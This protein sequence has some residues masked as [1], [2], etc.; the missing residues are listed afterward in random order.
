MPVH[1]QAFDSARPPD[2]AGGRTEVT[3]SRMR[4][5]KL[6]PPGPL[7][8]IPRKTSRHIIFAA[9]PIEKTVRMRQTLQ[10]LPKS[11]S[12]PSLTM[13]SGSSPSRP[14]SLLPRLCA[15]R[16]RD[17]EEPE[18]GDDAQPGAEGDAWMSLHCG[19]RHL[20]IPFDGRLSD[21]AREA[22]P[23]VHWYRKAE[24]EAEHR[25]SADRLSDS[26]FVKPTSIPWATERDITHAAMLRAEPGT[27]KALRFEGR[28]ELYAHLH[29]RATARG[30]EALAEAFAFKLGG[31]EEAHRILNLNGTGEISLMEFVGC[32]SLLGFDLH[33]L[34]GA[35]ERTAFSRIDI[36]N[37]GTIRVQDI[38][39]RHRGKRRGLL[40]TVASMAGK[41]PP[42][43]GPEPELPSAMAVS[44]TSLASTSDW[45][46]P[47]VGSMAGS[48]EDSVE[49]RLAKVKWIAIAKWMAA[50]QQRSTAIRDQRVRHG[51]E[52]NA[53]KSAVTEEAEEAA[54]PRLVSSRTALC[55]SS[56]AEESIVGNHPL[57]AQSAVSS[58]VPRKGPRPKTCS[59]VTKESAVAMREQEY[60]IR[61]SFSKS[62]S[63]SLPDGSKLLSKS[64]LWNFFQDLERVEQHPRHRGITQL[65][66]EREYHSAIDMQCGLTKIGTGLTFWSF[67]V[68]LNNIIPDMR[69]RWQSIVESE[70]HP[71]EVVVPDMSSLSPSLHITSQPN[72][73]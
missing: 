31:L 42:S 3:V 72:S 64:D 17:D 70:M 14:R 47:D 28:A 2:L 60:A 32:V 8:P 37:T 1:F 65:L 9:A 15:L 50:A 61:A 40:K 13:M 49:V 53:D 26:D 23:F 39:R 56:V 4:A 67:K 12:A 68:V 34:C 58:S 19:G 21:E 55:A 63:L 29:E 43:A 22:D 36:H 24:A 6:R 54:I 44:T 45:K 38:L 52:P 71:G 73:P 35:D 41:L 59:E 18:S 51:W 48:V 62:A 5:P 33:V 16:G 27:G 20:E 46:L 66:I 69:L 30:T 7:S 11:S 57:E 25:L 10:S